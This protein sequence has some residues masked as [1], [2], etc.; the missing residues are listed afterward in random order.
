MYPNY[1]ARHRIVS[2]GHAIACAVH[3]LSLSREA[4]I[5]LLSELSG[6]TVSS[7]SRSRSQDPNQDSYKSLPA[8]D[9]DGNLI[10]RPS[11]RGGGQQ[12]DQERR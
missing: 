6:Q 7:S 1:C 5:D 10:T 8:V 12:R 11:M 9:E 3:I 2:H 4:A